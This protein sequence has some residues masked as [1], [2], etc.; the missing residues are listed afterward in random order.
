[1]NEIG[2]IHQRMQ[3][4]LKRQSNSDTPIYGMIIHEAAELNPAARVEYIGRNRS[5]QPLKVDLVCHRINYGSWENW[6]W[7]TSNVPVMAGWEG[8]IDYRLN[9]TD[10]SK[11]LDTGRPSDVSNILYEGNAM[12][13]VSKIFSCSYCLEHNRY[14]YFCD[15]RISDDFSAVGFNVRGKERNHMLI[16][17]FYGSMDEKGRLRS[18]AGQWSAG[19]ISGHRTQNIYQNDMDTQ[20]QYLAVQ[21]SSVQSLFFGGALANVLTDIAV[22]LTKS[23]DSQSS[24]GAGASCS[25]TCDEDHSGHW[26]TLPNPIMSAQFYG[27]TDKKTYSS[28]FHSSV[29]GSNVLWQ[30][31]PY[32]LLV[33]GKLK[34]SPDYRFDLSGESYLDTGYSLPRG[35]FFAT[36]EV[37]PGFG[38]I[39][40]PDIIGSEFTGY[41]DHIYAN[42]DVISVPSR[43]GCSR[44]D[45]R[46]GLFARSM[47]HSGFNPNG[48]LENGAPLRTA[49]A[50]DESFSWW[51]NFG[52][53][54]MLPE[55]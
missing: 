46:A 28:I 32:T 14:V 9:P 16:P 51:W 15:E 42:P 45:A 21:R 33:H 2:Q 12:A 26:G 40:S 43:F 50:L 27:G 22:M 39:P 7:L 30:R 18:I 23:T 47:N 53:S 5:F 54:L 13:V 44:S 55:A 35:N 6:P 49:T 1:M 29:L 34:V 52:C 8:D 11:R 24:F 41:C 25:F 3:E 48:L 31:D 20:R 38:F 37:V 19:T 4:L 36:T 10:Y 17:M